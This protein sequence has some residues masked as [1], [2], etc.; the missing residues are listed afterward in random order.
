VPELAAADVVA[1]VDGYGQLRPDFPE[2]EKRPGRDAAARAREPWI[3]V[4]VGDHD[5]VAAGGADPL[6]P[7]L[8]YLPSARDLHLHLVICRPV[9][10]AAR[11]LYT[12][13]LQ[14]TRDTGAA[15]LLMS[16]DRTEG[17]LAGRVHAE[18]FASGRG[19]YV[20]SGA[21]PY[22]VQVAQPAAADATD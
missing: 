6:E 18:R 17:Q 15:T 7:L 1:L 3:V 13:V 9:A 21:P 19:R 20:R 2:L 4:L 10:G 8:P 12:A 11:A 14:T 16:G 22:V 5:I